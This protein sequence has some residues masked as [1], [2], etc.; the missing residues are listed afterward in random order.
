MHWMDIFVGRLWTS[1]PTYLVATKLYRRNE[2]RKGEDL[3]PAYKAQFCKWIGTRKCIFY[4][5]DF[6]SGLGGKLTA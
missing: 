3:S 5:S 1:D 2:S 6:F 4:G